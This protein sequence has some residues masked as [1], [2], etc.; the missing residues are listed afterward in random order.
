MVHISR[1][2]SVFMTLSVT[3]ERFTAIV[4]PLKRTA[5]VIQGPISAG[6]AGGQ[7]RGSSKGAKILILVSTLIA[8]AYNI[9]RYGFTLL[10][11]NYYNN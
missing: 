10:G 3:L 11:I 8:I 5:E 9:P 1:V 4:Y 6:R 2:G 7:S